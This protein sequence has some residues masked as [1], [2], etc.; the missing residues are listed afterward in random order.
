[1]SKFFDKVNFNFTKFKAEV[2][3]FEL[4]LNSKTE[5][6]ERTEILP[7]FN[8]HPI[9]TSHIATLLP[10]LDSPDQIA[11]E[12]DIFGDFVC[13]VA[14]GN[15][16][17][18]IYC[19]L[20]F[21]DATK[22]SLFKKEGKYQPAFSHRFEQGYSQIID[23]FT[24]IDGQSSQERINRFG[25]A[26]IDYHGVLVIGRDQFL[27]PRLLQRLKW[28]EKNVVVDNRK[29]YIYT[30]DGILSKMKRKVEIIQSYRGT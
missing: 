27:N 22:H 18:N 2:L 24:K 8:S 4:L 10:K 13:D 26:M 14:I 29:I 23:W 11:F 9:L 30:F 1:M 12:Y 15:T 7:F 20:E 19:F 3:D 17:E 25:S 6:K 16:A 5:L 21:E 28:R